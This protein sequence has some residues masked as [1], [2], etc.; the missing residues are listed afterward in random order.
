MRDARGRF[1]KAAARED[2]RLAMTDYVERVER[3]RLAHLRA[4]WSATEVV[5]EP[6]W[7]R[8]LGNLVMGLA[9]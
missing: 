6:S 2:A 5:P 4:F 8:R 3:Q 9:A 1:A 7:W